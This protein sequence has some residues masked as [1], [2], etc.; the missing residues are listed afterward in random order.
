MSFDA[1]K[2][3][4]SCLRRW[5]EGVVKCANDKLRSMGLAKKQESILL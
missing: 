5:E 4:Q 1:L 3:A 2:V